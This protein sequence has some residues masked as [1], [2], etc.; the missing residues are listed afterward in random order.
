MP[1]Q[2][3]FQAAITTAIQNAATADLALLSN[4]MTVLTST[5]NQIAT[6]AAAMASP[7]RGQAVQA[8][9]QQHAVVIAA[10]QAIITAAQASQTAIPVV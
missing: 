1:T 8:L 9:Q 7:A 2:A 6:L 3:Q 4:A 5:Q 10:L